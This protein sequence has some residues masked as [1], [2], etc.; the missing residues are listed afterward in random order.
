M[1]EN[2]LILVIVTLLAYMSWG[3][4]L[5]NKERNKLVNAIIAKHAQ[6]L[7]GIEAIEKVDIETKQ[8]DSVDDRYVPTEDVEDD[9]YIEAV[10]NRYS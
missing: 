3:R 1:I 4:Y 5:Q 6:D 7:S 10:N 8:P 9:D 2:V